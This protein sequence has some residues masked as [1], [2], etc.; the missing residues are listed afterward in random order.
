[1]LK[2]KKLINGTEE[3]ALPVYFY[4]HFKIFTDPGI[5]PLDCISKSPPPRCGNADNNT[6]T[7]SN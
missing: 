4:F 2:T 3:H 6:D 5:F 7:T 1:M